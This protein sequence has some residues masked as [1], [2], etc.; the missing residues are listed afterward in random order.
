MKLSMLG[1]RTDK[2]SILRMFIVFV[3]IATF[4]FVGLTLAI[5]SPMFQRSFDKIQT[6]ADKTAAQVNSDR[7]E[8]YLFDRELALKDAA[9]NPLIVNASLL[10]DGERPDFRDFLYE[11]RILGENPIVTVL[12][13]SGGILYTEL[14]GESFTKEVYSSD[15]PD[16]HQKIRKHIKSKTTY[17][18]ILDGTKPKFL[19]GVPVIY[20][21][22][23]QGF[24][25]AEISADPSILLDKTTAIQKGYG[26][27]YEINGHQVSTD[28]DHI[29]VMTREHVNTPRYGI[30]FTFIN[31]HFSAL[32]NKNLFNRVFI[33]TTLLGSICI[34]LTLYILGRRIIVKPYQEMLTSQQAIA[35]AVEGIAQI[36]TSGRYL[37]L[38]HAYAN[39]AGYTPEELEGKLW[40]KTVNPD[41]L[42]SLENAYKEMITKGKVSAEAKG[43]KK[44]GSLFYK[45]VTLVSRYDE[46]NKFIGHYCFMQDI[47]ERKTAE[48]QIYEQ[49]RDLKLIFDNVPVSIWYK[50]DKNT[51]LRLN[52]N[53]AES[54]G[55]TV[56][57]FEGKNTYDLF[58]EMAKKYHNDDLEVIY[59][60]K[61]KINI[62]E[63]YTPLNKPESWVSTDKI[64]HTDPSTGESF[65]FVCSQDITVIKESE[66]QK[67][68]LISQLSHS[69]K[70]LEQFA[71]IASHDLKSPLRGIEQLA[72]W[73][74]QDCQELL[75]EQSARHLSLMI[76][77]VQ[78]M[79]GLLEDLLEYSRIGR[80]DLSGEPVNLKVV[81]E[82]LCDLLVNPFGF[83]YSLQVPEDNII[84]ARKPFEIV[85]RNLLDNAVKHH[86][87]DTGTIS[88]S[89]NS[90]DGAHH[91]EVSDDGPGID[92]GMHEKAFKV[93]QT[94]QPRDK[95]E[96]SGMGL[97]IIKKIMHRYEGSID[98]H[99]DGNNGTTFKIVWPQI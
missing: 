68:Q 47:T 39:T 75:P 12:D 54:M 66:E 78:R 49:Q 43:I 73:I 32:K 56:E 35:S 64:P 82:D 31:D 86:D 71:Y 94:L 41:D 87:K 67:K 36:D 61:P 30:D 51:I 76:N 98:I 6:E 60:D 48:E 97:A 46:Q 27:S 16:F 7:L 8:Q 5:L 10:A 74:V 59:S 90:K 38:N 23:A 53:A 91:I 88:I 57:D 83:R 1:N 14:K 22:S 70:E 55:G 42:P 33:T 19:L 52:R 11:I 92:P 93:F 45:R 24:V 4:M 17:L 29:K 18:N 96:G 40:S 79:G 2:T 20:G 21:V 26:L 58:P 81:L 9:V 62:V 69:N 13:V 63:R 44:D 28:T 15:L 85:I 37:S 72:D 77:R 99:S 95:V 3:T 65:I 34:F 80:L 89:Y 25:I 84:I 50:D